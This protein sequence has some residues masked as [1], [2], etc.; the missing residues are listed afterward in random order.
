MAVA[1]R[2]GQPL[3][4]EHA[5]TLG[6][7]GAVGVLGERLA[8]AVRGQPALAAELH[9]GGRGSHDRHATGQRHRA[10]TVAQGLDRPVQSHQRGGTGRVH[11]HRGTFQAQGVGDA[12]G[13][14]AAG[15]AHAEVGLQPFR[16]DLNA[17]GVVVVHQP[18][19][20]TSLAA[21]Q[22]LRVDARALH[23]LPAGLQQ[24]ALLRV[25]GHG[26][27]R[28]DTEEGRVELGRVVQEAALASV[29]LARLVRVRVVQPV[30]VP[31]AVARE[32]ADRVGTGGQ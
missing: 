11:G 22:R 7:T 2:V 4:Q 26:L 17:G 29:G 16:R 20:D 3:H 12:P 21:L 23:G 32:L 28:G 24:Q 9:E 31:A 5:H 27:T 10:L 19:E 14:H 1:L 15:V 6:P 25:H 8:A 30:H 13:G 18:G